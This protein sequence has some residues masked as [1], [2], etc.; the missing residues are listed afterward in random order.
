MIHLMLGKH[1]LFSE[2]SG[3]QKLLKNVQTQLSPGMAL[4]IVLKRSQ[5][6]LS[7]FEFVT[8]LIILLLFLFLLELK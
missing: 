5:P 1:N 3:N 7:R 6:L 8:Y 4:V 2:Y